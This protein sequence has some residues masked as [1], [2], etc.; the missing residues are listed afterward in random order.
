MTARGLEIGDV[1][2]TY[3]QYNKTTWQYF[4]SRRTSLASVAAAIW[5]YFMLCCS[6]CLP[7]LQPSSLSFFLP[8]SSAAPPLSTLIEITVYVLSF[9]S[10]PRRIHLTSRCQFLDCASTAPLFSRCHN[11]VRG[12]FSLCSHI[13]G[14]FQGKKYFWRL[15][16]TYPTPTPTHTTRLPGSCIWQSW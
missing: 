10:Q 5:L 14:K 9:S 6:A 1:P 8:L 3:R 2:C 16:A 11:L 13:P 4:F 7:V 15:F 12:P